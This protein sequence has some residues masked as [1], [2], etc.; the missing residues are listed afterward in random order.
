MTTSKKFYVTDSETNLDWCINNLDGR[1][2]ATQH[3][4]CN[5]NIVIYYNHD[6]QKTDI[7]SA[8]NA[9]EVN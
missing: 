3:E 5:G 4:G 7:L 9:E 1:D 8:M 6:F 2:W